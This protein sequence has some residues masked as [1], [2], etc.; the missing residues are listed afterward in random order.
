MNCQKS[1]ML[2]NA[3]RYAINAV[4]FL[5]LE[6]NKGRK[7][8]IKAIA[9]E[10]NAP[11]PFLAKQLQILSRNKLVSSTKG[12]N[13]GFYLSEQNCKRK[14]IDVVKVLDGLSMFETCI[15]GLHNCSD[16]KPCPIHHEVVELR[17]ALYKGLK[18]KSIHEFAVEVEEGRTYIKL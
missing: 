10:I 7:T 11:T 12:P 8:G 5:A 13:G 9:E 16:K 2:S 3:S 14:L 17:N 4:I 1:I 6:K 15:L 18:E